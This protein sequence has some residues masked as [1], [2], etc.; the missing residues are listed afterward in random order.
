MEFLYDEAI[1]QF[2]FLKNEDE[3]CVYKKLSGSSIVFLELYVDDILL[4]RND[5]LMLD[6]VKQWLKNCFSMKDLGEA[7]YILGIKISKYWSKRLL[8]LRQRTYIDK[9]RTGLNM[10]NSKRGFLPMQ[11]GLSLCKTQCPSNE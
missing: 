7:E 10:E 11:H 3:P 2:G 6:S 9:V 1:I 4:I 8:G 5:I